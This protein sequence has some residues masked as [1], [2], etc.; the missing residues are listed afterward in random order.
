[1]AVR[2]VMDWKA[3]LWICLLAFCRL[4]INAQTIIFDSGELTPITTDSLEFQPGMPADTNH[5]D[6]K[7]AVKLTKD[8][9]Y[10]LTIKLFQ[11][12]AG[13]VYDFCLQ[14]HSS[15]KKVA[16]I[17]TANWNDYYQHVLTINKSHDGWDQ[18]CWRMKVPPGV[19]EGS[20]T[21]YAFN[22]YA[23]DG[24]VKDLIVSQVKDTVLPLFMLTPLFFEVANDYIINYQLHLLLNEVSLLKEGKIESE[25]FREHSTDLSNFKNS[26][27]YYL[28]RM[29]E[30]QLK[31]VMQQMRSK[32]TNRL[33]RSE[34]TEDML[35]KP[36][37]AYLK[38]M[39]VYV[40]SMELVRDTL[41]ED[42][43]AVL[44]SMEDNYTLKPL[45]EIKLEKKKV[46]DLP[47]GFLM[48]GFYNLRLSSVNCEFDI[49][50]IKEEPEPRSVCILA[51]YSTWQAYNA[52]G[53]KSFYR[54]SVDLEEVHYLSTNRPITSIHLDSVFGGHDLY[55]LRNLYHWFDTPYG[56]SIYPDYFLEK[57]VER[58][59][60]CSSLVLAQHCEYFTPGMYYNLK[61]LSMERNLL[62]LGGNQ[63]Y[64]KIRWN[65]S[66]DTVECRKDRSFFANSIIPGM[67][68]R[69]KWYG[70]ASL[71]GVEY[72]HAGIAT[73]APY[74]LKQTAHWLFKGIDTSR[75]VF[76]ERGLD[77]RGISGDET[78]KMMPYSPANTTLIAKGTNPE[79]GGGELVLIERGKYGTFSCGSIA[80][81]AGI[82]V[83]NVFT[84]LIKNFME[85]YHLK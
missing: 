13:E 55:I 39:I 52:Y 8:S 50:F 84:Q 26:I 2:K 76:G 44:Y 45:K 77:G 60:G 72:T 27:H 31:V 23:E 38:E 53:G 22:Y 6:F 81:A 42:T 35:K 65:S 3:I 57:E 4:T 71:L 82:G 61:Q 59:E 9:P 15:Y 70:E 79:G 12:S 25:I 83:D 67:H 62:A 74:T 40:D 17:V 56:A 24:Y 66:F 21:A 32:L 63:I 19:Q 85:K 11:L 28:S 30:D 73:Y 5:P 47:I 1:M 51:P 41:M 48:K 69:N 54:N 46:Q 37:A 33:K 14:R 78:D 16:L 43:R 64:W 34:L 29:G 68:W 36:C 80:C 20:I 49:P 58:L 7:D 18:L 75:T 10:A